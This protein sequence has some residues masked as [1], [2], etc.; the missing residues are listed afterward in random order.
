MTQSGTASLA[1][2]TLALAG[3]A[4]A[5]AFPLPAS[6]APPPC[7]RAYCVEDE[8]TIPGEPTEPTPQNEPRP[9]SYAPGGGVARC[10]WVSDPGRLPGGDG[11]PGAFPDVGPR[12]ADDAY[13]IFERCD[14]ELTG[15]VQWAT[16]ADPAPA[17]PAGPTPAAPTPEQLAATIRVR[18]EGDLPDPVVATSPPAG[19]SAVVNHPTFLAIDNWT[20]T[21]TD[22]ECAG[23][24]CVTVTA[25]PTLTWTPG[26][27]GTATLT[28]T[29]A[30]TTYNPTGAPPQAQA[31]QPGAC[32][33]AYQSRTGV[34]GRPNAW[35]GTAIVTWDLT[36]TSTT[37]AGGPLP[38]ITRSAPL[39]RAVD[40]VQ[41]V[42]VH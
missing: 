20:G 6:G 37:S 18:L 26:E 39:P 36:W 16:P 13:L 10:T 4:V 2:L 5:V 28:C 42:V 24:L 34:A 11:G 27:P 14:G 35:P 31:A 41:A 29:G 40:E 30:G 1:T 23:P 9:V 12:P 25:T 3:S 17:G 7:D 22:Q 8:I 33:H 38:P 21:I 19:D 15:R 32:A